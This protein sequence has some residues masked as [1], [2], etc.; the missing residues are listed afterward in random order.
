VSSTAPVVQL[1]LLPDALDKVPRTGAVG[2]IQAGELALPEPASR[3]LS[4]EFLG[5]AAREYWRFVTRVSLGLVRV[6][7]PD[8]DFH[9]DRA[10]VTWRI[11][12][13]LLVA[14]D[15]RERGFLRFSVAELDG[16]DAGE[17]G[18]ARVEMEVRNFYPWLRGSGRFARVGAWL[19]GH[20][21]QRAHRWIT[22]GF[23]RAMARD[24]C[25]I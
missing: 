4:A 16:Q 19:Y 25:Y 3:L 10:S 2:S 11:E 7:E 8:Y 13:G 6:R 24:R 17:P 1:R 12:R 18:R 23:L 5:R 15:G 14:G 22:R 20:T 21:Q 9:P